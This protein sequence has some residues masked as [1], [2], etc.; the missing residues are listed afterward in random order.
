ME[1]FQVFVHPRG[2][3]IA[4][5]GTG[6]IYSLAVKRE[7]MGSGITLDISFYVDKTTNLED[8]EKIMRQSY[9]NRQ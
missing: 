9:R 5:E 4:P 7:R 8:V 6:W 1:P 2:F 3:D